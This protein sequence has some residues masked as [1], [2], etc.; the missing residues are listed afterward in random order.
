MLTDQ[1]LLLDAYLDGYQMT[2]DKAYLAIA[3]NII[4]YVTDHLAAPDGAFYASQHSD[5][6]PSSDAAQIEEGAHYIWKAKEF[7]TAVGERPDILAYHYGVRAG[8]N[9]PLENLNFS[10]TGANILR[11]EKSVAEVA[12]K[13]NLT[14]EEASVAIARG[15]AALAQARTHRPEPAVNQQIVT[16]SN[17]L[18]ISALAH[19]S[20]ASGEED[21]LDHAIRAM[22]F[23]HE[24]CY[25]A[26]T[27]T[28]YRIY[29]PEQPTRPGAT[30]DYA[31][32]VQA[33]LDL[34]AAGFDQRWLKFADDPAENAEQTLLRQSQRRV[35]QHRPLAQRCRDPPQ[36]L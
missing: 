17:G 6:L 34:Y 14:E 27:G 36:E 11:V 24:R 32:T 29:N 21:Y 15:R 22:Q 3:T 20:V 13:F 16:A 5:S 9:A 30:D 10:S 18:M 23:I 35:L 26:D 12:A 19:A 4:R 7:A 28:L 2:G 33:C 25:D 8:G 31:F 1:A